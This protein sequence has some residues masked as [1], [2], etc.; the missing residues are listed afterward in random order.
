[1]TIALDA[2]IERDSTEAIV[3][4]LTRE[5]LQRQG[6]NGSSSCISP[7]SSQSSAS[8]GRVLEKL[9]AVVPKLTNGDARRGRNLQSGDSC[10]DTGG[11]GELATESDLGTSKVTKPLAAS[12]A[13]RNTKT[14][15][16]A[17]IAGA[18]VAIK[19]PKRKRKSKKPPTTLLK[20]EAADFLETV[21]RLT[22]GTYGCQSD[23]KAMPLVSQ[24]SATRNTVESAPLL[25]SRPEVDR[26]PVEVPVATPAVA[27]PAAALE[28]PSDLLALLFQSSEGSILNEMMG[29]E[30]QSSWDAISATFSVPE[31]IGG[32]SSTV[33]QFAGVYSSKAGSG[34][35]T[36]FSFQTPEHM[37][38]QKTLSATECLKHSADYLPH[39]DDIISIDSWLM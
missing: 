28:P 32:S 16:V 25:P 26:T 39:E 20:I 29:Y 22:G 8:R 30:N 18:G 24:P 6:T 11:S 9:Q 19:K 23:L 15:P 3:K 31:N 13:A 27:S 21:R 35:S 17:A 2:K 33:S 37:D 5:L 7:S 38:R 14:L 36:S 4:C 10:C 34:S 12:S 1:M